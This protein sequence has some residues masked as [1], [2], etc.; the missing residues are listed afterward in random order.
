MS[1]ARI[2]NPI[3]TSDTGSDHFVYLNNVSYWD[4]TPELAVMHSHFF[5][6]YAKDHD[7]PK[8]GRGPHPPLAVTKNV[9]NLTPVF[10][11]NKMLVVSDIV[12][13][14]IASCSTAEFRE[15][16]IARAFCFPYGPGIMSYESAGIDLEGRDEH[17]LERFAKA[18]A[19]PAPSERYYEVVAVDTRDVKARY[20][21]REVLRYPTEVPQG[22]SLYS[23]DRIVSRA[24]VREHGLV[25][26]LGYQF[27]PDLF[28]LL[29]PYLHRPW[30]WAQRYAYD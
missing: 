8:A 3:G 6:C 16:R 12:R 19:C 7:W 10:I 9:Y 23:D 24:M 29:N 11:I 21:D 15:I 17:V 18:F 4:T 13:D 26:S 28:D 27:R 22:S 2:P 20:K 14:L 25:Y 1:K 30:F 5:E